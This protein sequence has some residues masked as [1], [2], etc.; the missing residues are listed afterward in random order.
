MAAMEKK[1]EDGRVAYEDGAEAHVHVSVTHVAIA[2]LPEETVKE[3]L[4]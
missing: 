1:V 4:L 3:Y 2:I